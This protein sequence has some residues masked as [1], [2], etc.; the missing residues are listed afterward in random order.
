MAM[1]RE[2]CV[3][4]D[5]PHQDV[6]GDALREETRKLQRPAS[7]G[8]TWFGDALVILSGF[9]ISGCIHDYPRLNGKVER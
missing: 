4:M 8:S 1:Y 3:D 9:E 6:Q 7:E 2:A 5:N